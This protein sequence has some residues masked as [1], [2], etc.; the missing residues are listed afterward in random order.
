VMILFASAPAAAPHLATGRVKAIAVTTGKRATMV[1]DIPTIAES[2]FPGFNV[3]AWHGVLVPA[4]TPRETIMKLNEELAQFVRSPDARRLFTQQG[5]D[6]AAS[7]PE[8]FG[9]F[10]KSE[11]ALYARVTGR[12]VIETK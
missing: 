10:L 8:E 2:G 3:G 11:V 7:T 5:L 12:L 4:R 9:A 1:P 6:L